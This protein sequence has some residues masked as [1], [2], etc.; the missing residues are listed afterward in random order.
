M[1]AIS[2]IL[3][4][5]VITNKLTPSDP[6]STVANQGLSYCVFGGSIKKVFDSYLRDCMSI[7]PNKNA[8]KVFLKNSKV[9][10]DVDWCTNFY[11]AYGQ[12]SLIPYAARPNFL[13]GFSQCYKFTSSL[14]HFHFNYIKL[15]FDV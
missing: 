1:P 12:T 10:I 14:A 7:L 11:N 4:G 3:N 5:M 15:I 13:F 2:S 8:V 6:K 9:Y